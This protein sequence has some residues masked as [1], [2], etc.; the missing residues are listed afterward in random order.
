MDE[1]FLLGQWSANE[2][3]AIEASPYAS[4]S[5][6]IE[7]NVVWREGLEEVFSCRPVLP[8]GVVRFSSLVKTGNQRFRAIFHLDSLEAL[9]NLVCPLVGRARFSHGM[10]AHYDGPNTNANIYLSDGL[11]R[12]AFEVNAYIHE[13]NEM[14]NQHFHIGP[15]LAL[16]LALPPSPLVLSAESHLLPWTPDLP[17]CFQLI[18]TQQGFHRSV[19]PSA[20]TWFQFPPG[21]NIMRDRYVYETIIPL[22]SGSLGDSQVYPFDC[23]LPPM[24]LRFLE[25]ITPGPWRLV[26]DRTGNGVLNPWSNDGKM[27]FDLFVDTPAEA[28]TNDANPLFCGHPANGISPGRYE[29]FG[30]MYMGSGQAPPAV[31]IVAEGTRLLS[32]RQANPE[33]GVGYTFIGGLRETEESAYFPPTPQLLALAA[34]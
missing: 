1:E 2:V 22:G 32:R 25:V 12:E 7:G 20:D 13:P 19:V 30:L 9:E 29:V 15:T 24:T 4:L 16:G 8:P 17:S 26:S 33:L 6:T 31:R 10:M 5:L 11:I 21:A 3:G 27:A 28:R 18:N 23:L 14:G 34:E